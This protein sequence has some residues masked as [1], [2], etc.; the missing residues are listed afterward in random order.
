MSHGAVGVRPGIE[1]MAISATNGLAHRSVR[2]VFEDA[3]NNLWIGT[4]SSG[5]YRLRQRRFLNIGMEEGLPDRIVRTLTE[6]GPGRILAGTHGGGTVRIE[7]GARGLGAASDQ[8]QP[9]R[10]RLEC[11]PRP[12]RAHLDRHISSMAC[13][14]RR[15]GWNDPFRCRPRWARA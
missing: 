7:G 2:Y 12:Q 10:I 4:T 1:Q 14:S 11:S 8:R 13:C 3:E 5:L 6:E 15:T 9:L